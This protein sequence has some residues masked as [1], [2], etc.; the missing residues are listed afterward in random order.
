[1]RLDAIWPVVEGKHGARLVEA[2]KRVV[3]SWDLCHFANFV[4]GR[5]RWVGCGCGDRILQLVKDMGLHETLSE[6]G[7]GKDQVDIITQRAT[8]AKEGE[9]F[10]KVKVLVEGLY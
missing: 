3:C 4:D 2:A 9:L 7:V 10:D 1:M 6:R 8:G 5:W